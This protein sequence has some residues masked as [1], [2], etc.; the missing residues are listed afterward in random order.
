MRSYFQDAPRSYKPEGGAYVKMDQFL[1]IV[2]Q[3]YTPRS[4]VLKMGFVSESG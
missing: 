2:E 1:A 3:F 4:S